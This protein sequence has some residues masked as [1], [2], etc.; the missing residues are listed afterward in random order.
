ME[1]VR[2]VQGFVEDMVSD[3]RNLNQILIVASNSRWKNF[4]SEIKREY[5]RLVK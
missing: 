3:G 2:T 1:N 5:R 4:K